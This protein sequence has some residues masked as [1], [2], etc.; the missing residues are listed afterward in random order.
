DAI[1]MGGEGGRLQPH[2]PVER[3]R[4]VLH[5]DQHT[6]GVVGRTHALSSLMFWAPTFGAPITIDPAAAG[7]NAV[8]SR[9]PGVKTPL[10]TKAWPGMRAPTSGES[11]PSGGFSSPRCRLHSSRA[12]S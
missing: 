1:A 4:Q 8:S 7:C 9:S 6:V 11:H 5:H 2:A 12:G 3:D 10:P